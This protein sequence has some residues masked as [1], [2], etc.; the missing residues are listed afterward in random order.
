M[1]RLAPV[2]AACLLAGCAS[3]PA[4]DGLAARVDALLA[5]RV[6]AREFS[7]AV[8][9]T[10]RGQVVYERGFGMANHEAGA[11]FTPDTP[12]DGG[13]LAKT[14]TAAGV[15]WLAQE[16]RIDLDAPVTRYLPGFPHAATTVRHLVTHAN[17]L[18]PY[19]EAFDPHV[20][21]GAVRTTQ[22]LLAVTARIAPQPAFAPGTRFEYSNLGF[23]AAALVI[24]RVT[25]LGYEAFLRERFLA[26]LAMSRTFARPARFSDWAGVRT[27]GYEWKAGAWQVVDVYDGEAFLGASNLYF[28]AADLSRWAR[29]NA[30]GTAVPPEVLAAGQE[31]PL[32]GGRPSHITGLSWYCDDAR[33]RCY[34]TGSLNA[35]HGLAYWDRRRDETVVM[36]SNSSVPPWPLATLQ[37]DLVAVLAGEP[38][39]PAPAP[40]FRALDR[41][42]RPGAAG[43][44]IAQGLGTV[45]VTVRAG[46]RLR[47]QAGDGLAF[48]MFAVSPEVFYVPGPDWWVAFGGGG[49]RPDAMHV[50]GMFVDAVARRLP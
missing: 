38:L 2:L 9:L 8:V 15:W 24:E 5:P 19:Y 49:E 43:A 40:A 23:D 17:G 13:S 30:A 34:Y 14:F 36:V 42:T 46:N 7:G 39:Q 1:R 22:D 29:A 11:P 45:T 12:T 6:A 25:G 4:D 37:R 35:F 10:R 47:L 44:W 21:P 28:S 31:R 41:N 3:L 50:R 27:M 48:D 32:L 16:G 33:E 18:P 20:A 26:R